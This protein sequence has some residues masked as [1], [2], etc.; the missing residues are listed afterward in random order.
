[1][2]VADYVNAV[3]PVTPRTK[4]EQIVP[5]Q[6]ATRQGLAVFQ[7]RNCSAAQA[8]VLSLWQLVQGFGMPEFSVS[9][10]VIK[11]KV[12][13]WQRRCRRPAYC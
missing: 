2:T 13:G 8:F 4:Q 5:Y 10:G 9:V 6:L 1:V 7:E 3:E 12:Y 11:R